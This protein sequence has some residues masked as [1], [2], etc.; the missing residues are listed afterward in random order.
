MINEAKKT[1]EPLTFV[2][3]K[4][5]KTVEVPINAWQALNQAA[6]KL[7]EIAMF[8]TTMEMVGQRH[9]TDG[10]LIP[11]FKEDTEPSGVKNPDGT[12]QLKIKDAFWNQYNPETEDPTVTEDLP[13]EE[14]AAV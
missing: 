13:K 10:T 2:Y 5:K 3:N 11:V 9:M 6:D 12:D 7:R 14:S 8:V 1:K 4:Y